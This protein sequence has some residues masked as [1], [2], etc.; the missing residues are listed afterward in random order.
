MSQAATVNYIKGSTKMTRELRQTHFMLEKIATFTEK[1]VVALTGFSRK[2]LYNLSVS[3]IVQPKKNPIT[4]NWNQLIFLRV[5]NLLREDWSLQVLEKLFREFPDKGIERVIELIDGSL[6][7]I[8]IAEKSGVIEFK[9]VTSLNFDD[10][11]HNQFFKRAID[12][13]KNS[14]RLSYD[15]AS[16]I[17]SNVIDNCREEDGIKKI[18]IKKQTLL[19][20]PEVIRELRKAAILPEEQEDITLKVG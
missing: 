8:L 3:E 15:D 20:V 5:L 7:V 6:A 11:I 17:I 4:Y 12:K 10:D 14:K 1:Q 16:A 19:I 9:M 18:S 13:I 2:Q